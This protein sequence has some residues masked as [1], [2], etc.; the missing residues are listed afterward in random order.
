MLSLSGSHLKFAI[1]SDKDIEEVI[2]K[3]KP[4]EDALKCCQ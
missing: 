1:V 2:K 3:M 4:N